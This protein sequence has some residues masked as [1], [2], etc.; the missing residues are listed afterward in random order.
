MKKK[1]IIGVTGSLA[2]GKSMVSG[3]FA[4]QGALKIDADEITHRLL[5]KDPVIKKEVVSVF[6]EEILAAG[7]IDRKKLAGKVFA[8]K[9]QLKRLSEIMH[10]EIIRI[11]KAAAEQHPERVIVIDAPLL[12][13]AGLNDF[14]D[15]VVVVK[16][17]EKTQLKRAM[18]RGLTQEEAKKIISSQMAL[19]EKERLA[20]FI[21]DNDVDGEMEKV[22]KGVEDVWE[23]LWKNP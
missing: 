12:I 3:L 10:P 8:D 13:E 4:G 18:G 9:K 11:I 6:G 14:V 15:I 23:N 22:K 16:A 2:T 7:E 21:I 1:R 19:S 20:D 17:G 5:A